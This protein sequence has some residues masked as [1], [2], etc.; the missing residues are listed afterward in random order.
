MKLTKLAYA[1]RLLSYSYFCA[2]ILFI[3]PIMETI[4]AYE[5]GTL[6]AKIILL[7]IVKLLL[8]FM[9]SDDYFKRDK[10]FRELMLRC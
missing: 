5:H 7:L 10:K 1:I 4:K 6:T 8:L 9:V 3:S 2:W